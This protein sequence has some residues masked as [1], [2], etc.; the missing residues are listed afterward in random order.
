MKLSEFNLE[1]RGTKWVV[2]FKA[3]GCQPATDVE[4]ALWLAADEHNAGFLA[5]M[6]K[7]ADLVEAQGRQWG[8]MREIKMVWFADCSRVLGAFIRSEANRTREGA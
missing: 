2:V 5:G 7:A 1:K 6:A 3:G 8:I 4:V